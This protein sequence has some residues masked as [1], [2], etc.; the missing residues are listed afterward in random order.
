MGVPP[1]ATLTSAGRASVAWAK[2]RSA[3]FRRAPGNHL[4]PGID[5]SPS[6]SSYWVTASSP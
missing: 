5:A 2:H 3:K 4:A 1:S 6:T